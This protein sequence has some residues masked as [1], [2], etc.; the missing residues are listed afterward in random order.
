MNKK[1]FASLTY[2]AVILYIIVFSLITIRNL[3]L[4]YL[5]ARD[6]GAFT[7]IFWN[8]LN[9]R[10]FMST[11]LQLNLENSLG[12]HFWP[13]IALL[14]PLLL[15]WNHPGILLV[16][17]SIAIGT[18]ALPLFWLAR[19]ITKNHF[20]AFSFALAFL[21][22]PLLH[23]AHIFD[24]HTE[25]LSV[26][27]IIFS[28]FFL[29]RKRT[30]PY[31]I[32]LFLLLACKE[33]SSLYAIIFGLY[34]LLFRKQ[35]KLG[36]I[37]IIIGIS[38][39]VIIIKFIMPQFSSEP[40]IEYGFLHRYSWLGNSFA[41]ITK[42]MLFRPLYVARE[43]L[44][45]LRIKTILY[46]L[47][48]VACLPLLAGGAFI[49]ILPATAE[50]ILS[51]FTPQIQLI[52]HY[53][54]VVVPFYFIAAV[55]GAGKLINKPFL[56]NRNKKAILIGSYL[57]MC[58]YLYAFFMGF[59]PQATITGYSPLHKDFKIELYAYNDHSNAGHRLISLIP[60]NTSVVANCCSLPLLA[61]RKDIYLYRG[62][63]TY[64]S[65]DIEIEYILLDL[66]GTCFPFFCRANPKMEIL[67][68]L[69][70]NNYGVMAFDNGWVLLRK[71]YSPIKNNQIFDYA[72]EY[73]TEIIPTENLEQRIGCQI[74]DPDAQNRLALKGS[75]SLNQKGHLCYGPYYPY[76]PGEYQ[77]DFYL[78]TNERLSQPVVN[79]DVCTDEGRKILA[80][81][82]IAGTDF[83]A[84]NT[85]NVFSLK[86]TISENTRLEFRVFFLDQTD[87]YID[88][89]KVHFPSISTQKKLAFL[90]KINIK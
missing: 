71:G 25:A 80:Q 64:F 74:A 40:N 45:P 76:P 55:F 32:S 65:K 30:I 2:L 33:D 8:T 22:N 26:A 21:M 47:V 81:R 4:F 90:E 6:M 52:G 17:Q 85:Y 11:I 72:L 75:V 77:I 38:W 18:A 60:N 83:T 13:I 16:I 31:F 61:N 59:S 29:Y 28:F 23:Q 20:L 57:I 66:H 69:A 5:H 10:F 89:I 14:S 46:L 82:E 3:N 7:N 67:N 62:N 84:N 70:G 12:V 79:I 56:G 15:I 39:G 41:E 87:I 44:T 54:F 34:A 48:P 43:L 42:T 51:S 88:Y 78:K 86:F 73:Y 63:E 24:F 19:E 49:L 36:L 27:F 53:A 1:L 35:R 58:N 37:S 50:M 68:L 9:G